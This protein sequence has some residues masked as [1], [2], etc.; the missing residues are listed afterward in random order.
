MGWWSNAESVGIAQLA[1][2]SIDCWS[3]NSAEVDEP[4]L[5]SPY[6]VVPNNMVRMSVYSL[7]WPIIRT[8]PPEWAHAL[9]LRVLRWP[10]RW[11]PTIHDPFERQGLRCRNRVG[12]AAG[13]DKNAVALAGAER[14]GAG[15]IE[16]GTILVEPWAGNLVTPRVRRLV[17]H[18]A[19][20]NRLGFTSLGL[21]HIVNNLQQ[22]TTTSRQGMALLCNIGPHPKRLRESPDPWTTARNDL[23]Q[24]VDKLD[25]FA[26]A[27]VVNLSSPNTPGLR[28]LLQSESLGPS[29]LQPL[30]DQL[31]VSA[32]RLGRPRRTP[33]FLKLPPE[34][35][36]RIPWHLE[37]LARVVTPLAESQLVDGFVAVN[38]STRLAS[39]MVRFPPLDLPG[40]VSGEPLRPEAIRIVSLLRDLLGPKPLVIGCGGIMKPAD[41]VEFLH[42]GAD[43]VEM[44][45]GL[46]YRGPSLLSECAKALREVFNNPAVATEP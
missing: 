42:A 17:R 13:F 14:M 20:W 19:I 40:G 29:L 3:D 41:A 32:D 10:W 31:H 38:T 9:A 34:D 8:L 43:L 2:K 4:P 6:P 23:R 28:S 21:P 39:Q 44:Y 27:F 36:D 11:G 22:S 45:T 24:L 25:P 35:P 37:S 18:Q 1:R 15:F 7:L 30:I 5:D 16:V 46:V 26:D 33:L 12:I